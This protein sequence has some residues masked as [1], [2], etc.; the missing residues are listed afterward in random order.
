MTAS[1]QGAGGEARAP[2]MIHPGPDVE[3]PLD[4]A[5]DVQKRRQRPPSPSERLESRVDSHIA[6][7]KADKQRLRE[8]VHRLRTQEIYHLREDVRWL[9]DR[10]DWQSQELTRTRTAYASA[11]AFSWFSFALVVIGGGV[12]SYAT[13]VHP[14]MQMTIATGALVCLFIGVVVQGINSWVGTGLL[15]RTS[16]P[17]GAGTRPRPNPHSADGPEVPPAP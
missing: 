2:E 1:E 8:E 17:P 14:G 6:E 11:V 4:L 15:R 12:V 9:E 5:V 7:L 3:K 10:V 16:E 13:F